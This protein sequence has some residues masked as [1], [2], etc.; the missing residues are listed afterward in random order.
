[1]VNRDSFV[2]E[3]ARLMF[4]NFAGRER[5]F[6]SAGDR[7][8]CILLEPHM[9]E[10]L[11][12]DGW[13]VKELKVKEEGETPQAYIQVTVNYSKGRP[14][15][16]VLISSR[17]RNDL[18]AD[19]VE[20]LDV[21]DIARADVSLNPY[22]WEVRDNKGVKAYLKS[23]YVTAQEDELDIKYAQVP[24]KAGTPTDDPPPWETPGGDDD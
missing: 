5:E 15:R 18:G 10:Q 7:N 6:N 12:H 23:I 24:E 2:I 17:G 16:C 9:A 1:M 4:R 22:H 19:E 21:V 13:N 3:D 8:F 14:P 11:R 20:I